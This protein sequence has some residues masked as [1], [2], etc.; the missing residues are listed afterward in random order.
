[1]Q[2]IALVEPLKNTG[3]S[4]ELCLRETGIKAPLQERLLCIEVRAR[5]QILEGSGMVR[6]V[7]DVA[8]EVLSAGLR[9]EN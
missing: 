9:F 8:S 1:M 6:I 7:W 2:N 4:V 5:S 3:L